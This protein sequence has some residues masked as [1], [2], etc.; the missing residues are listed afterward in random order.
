MKTES[1]FVALDHLLGEIQNIDR[2]KM[3]DNDFNGLVI[4]WDEVTEDG[5]MITV[6][7]YVRKEHT[8]LDCSLR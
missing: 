4:S 7:E 2:D 6:V 8:C 5:E 3:C 1:R